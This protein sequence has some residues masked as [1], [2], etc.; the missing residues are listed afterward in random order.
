[1]YLEAVIWRTHPD[2]KLMVK[3]SAIAR[4]PVLTSNPCSLYVVW[5]RLTPH[6]YVKS[7]WKHVE[8]P[9]TTPF[10]IS[11]GLYLWAMS[12]EGPLP[13]RRK[14]EEITLNKYQNQE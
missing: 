4:V 8:R 7:E 5:P 11:H 6:K 10:S 3:F 1:M 9:V 2:A 14:R 12:A 13:H